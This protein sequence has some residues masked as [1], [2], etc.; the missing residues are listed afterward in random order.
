[1]DVGFVLTRLPIAVLAEVAVVAVTEVAVE[2]TEVAEVVTEVAEVATA[3]SRAAV[4]CISVHRDISLEHDANMS[5][6]VGYGG[7]SGGY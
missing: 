3:A 4:V 5:D 6:C 7:Q 1:M 2:A